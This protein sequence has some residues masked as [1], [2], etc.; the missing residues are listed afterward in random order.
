VVVLV[1]PSETSFIVHKHLL[2]K[3]SEYFAKA[4][5]GPWIE[6][7]SGTIKLASENVNVFELFIQWLYRNRIEALNFVDLQDLLLVV[8]VSRYQTSRMWF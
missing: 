7:Q 5:S 3:S 6:A 1:G 8:I 4:I 2:V